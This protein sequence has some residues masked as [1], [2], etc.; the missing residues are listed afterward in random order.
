MCVMRVRQ[1][2]SFVKTL[3]TYLMLISNHI[4]IGSMEKYIQIKGTI[5]NEIL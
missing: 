1:F 5:W 3:D 2:E 4:L